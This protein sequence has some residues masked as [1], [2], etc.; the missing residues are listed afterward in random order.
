MTPQ[1]IAGLRL[2]NQQLSMQQFST[3]A[4]V[5][6]W[7]GA[8]QAQDFN[9]VKWAVGQRMQKPS[10][11]AVEN[12]LHTG[13]ILRTWPMR[14]T[15]HLVPAKDARWMLTL[16]NERVIAA[17]AGRHSQLGLTHRDLDKS[18]KAVSTAL[19]GGKHI[20]RSELYQVL[21][22]A[23]V[24]PD[25]QRGMHVLAHLAFEQLIVFGRP[26][27]KEQTFT[28]FD[29]W[30]P[31][32]KPLGREDASRKLVSAYFK[33]HGPATVQD[34]NWWS[35]LSMREIRAAL[36]DLAGQFDS[37]TIGGRIYYWQEMKSGPK[38]AAY[39]L[40]PFDEYLVSYKYRGDVLMELHRNQ[41]ISRNGMFSPVLVLN[42]QV[43]GTWAKR[44]R[45]RGL[46]IELNL[47]RS[48]R[49]AEK[50]DV[51]EAA[52][53]YSAFWNLPLVEVE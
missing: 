7:L 52:E 46:S 53:R 34:M 43:V 2:R 12:A 25:G 28:L 11:R 10:L 19:A 20:S 4:K 37:A 13:K 31:A 17:S 47:F 26:A 38:Q 9:A 40:A 51:Q 44:L 8:M 1:D 45:A 14:R 42:G 22:R 33:S 49:S 48:L 36:H 27:G 32:T 15:L 6:E 3:P 23:G 5:V 39:L 35:G 50:H 30:V 18:R 16:L 21:K 41:V 29:D 24:A